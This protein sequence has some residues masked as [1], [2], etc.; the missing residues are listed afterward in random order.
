MASLKSETIRLRIMMVAVFVLG[1]VIQSLSIFWES[2]GGPKL[3]EDLALHGSMEMAGSVIAAM[4]AYLLLRL[5]SIGE[6]S[7]FNYQIAAALLAMSCL[8]GLHAMM[9]GGNIFVWLH[10][11]AT[12]LG[13]LLFAMIWVPGFSPKSVLRF[14]P[15]NAVLISIALGAYS[16]IRP[17]Q[18]PLMLVAGEFTRAAVI[19]NIGGGVFLLL[20]ATKLFSTYRRLEKPEDLL[21]FFQCL[22]LAS[23]AI[24]FMQSRIWDMPWWGWHVQRLAGYALTLWL[25]VKTAKSIEAKTLLS[26]QL[27]TQQIAERK[28]SEAELRIASVAFESHESMMITGADNV[29]LRVNR[30]FTESTGYAAEEAV[31]R[32]PRLLKSGRHDAAFYRSMWDSIQ[33]TGKWEGEIWDRRKNG[34]LYPKWLTISAVKGENGTVTHYVGSHIDISER[35][36]AEEEVQQLAFF[37]P[38]TKLPNRRLLLDRLLH[39]MTSSARSDRSVALLFIDL[40]NFKALNDTLGHNMGD[41]LLQ[42]VA[43]RLASCVREGDSV[44]RLGGDEFVVLLEDLSEHVIEAAEQTENI[45]EKILASLCKPYQLDA[46][47][48][49]STPSIGVTVFRGHQQSIEELLKQAD[50]AMYQAKKAGRNTLRFFDRGMQDSV[51][52]RV[53][54]EDELRRAI[55]QQQFQLYYQVQVDSSRHPLGAEALIRWIHPERGMVSP[56]QFIPLAEETGLILPIGQWVLE[57]ACAQLKTWEQDAQARDLIVSVNI[58]ARQF[59]QADFVDQVRNTVQF[60]AI[61]PNLLMLELT[62]SML[63]ENIEDTIATMNALKEIGI[64]FSLDDFGNGYSSLRYLKRLPLDQIKIDQAFVR[65][66]ATDSNDKAIVSTIIAMANSLG[67]DVIAEGVETEMQ[68]QLLLNRGCTHHQG[69]LFSKPVPIGQFELLLRQA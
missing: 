23:A 6:G 66:I 41:L 53:A 60:H 25:V 36:R 35:K 29:I 50:I 57:T 10:S 34:E 9:P 30:A 14:W 52:A 44:A 33:R 2:P 69:Y 20:A 27:L 65:D 54:L 37:D 4:V 43:L 64:R 15:V 19:M 16:L 38:L 59:C 22:I 8:D 63:L 58:S 61:N 26:N 47:E 62:E 42:Q 56:V 46:H 40:D 3:L 31:G 32:T 45:G 1:I 68:R 49:R 11:L 51:T 28:Q 55:G 7:S 48:Y 12:F 24:M 17:D 18:I 67:F 21:F 5:N 13:G 39:A